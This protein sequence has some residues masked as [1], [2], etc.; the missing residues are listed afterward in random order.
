MTRKKQPQALNDTALRRLPTARYVRIIRAAKAWTGATA[1][2]V[3]A[4]LPKLQSE[5]HMRRA[6]ARGWLEE[7]DSKPTRYRA[8]KL[9]DE[10]AA[11]VEA[12]AAAVA[13]AQAKAAKPRRKR[14][15]VTRAVTVG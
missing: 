2:M 12:L 15:T 5:S 14:V 10:L 4:E 8:T 9:G 7:D 1:I 3:A 6:V 13:K 11:Q